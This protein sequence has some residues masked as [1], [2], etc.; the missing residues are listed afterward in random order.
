[1]NVEACPFLIIKCCDGA[2]TYEC[3]CVPTR[4]SIRFPILS[5]IL[6]ANPICVNI[7]LLANLKP[8][9]GLPRAGLP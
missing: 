6:I 2:L 7:I 4:L 3:N 8:W 1:M 9:T 5:G